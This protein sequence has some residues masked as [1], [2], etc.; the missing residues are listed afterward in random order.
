[1]THQAIDYTVRPARARQEKPKISAFL[2]AKINKIAKLHPD[3]VLGFSDLQAD[4][5]AQLLKKGIQVTIFNQRSV[6]EMFSMMHGRIIADDGV[7]WGQ[8]H[9]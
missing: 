3:C 8:H 4:I 6:A 1:M 7:A 9:A 2:S 5:A